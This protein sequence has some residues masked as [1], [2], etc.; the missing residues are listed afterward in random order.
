MTV[1]QPVTVIS[2]HHKGKRI[3]QVHQHPSNA[4][5]RSPMPSI[6][7]HPGVDQAAL[8]SDTAVYPEY[9]PSL[10][11]PILCTSSQHGISYTYLQ[12]ISGQLVPNCREL[13]LRLRFLTRR[14]C[15]SSKLAETFGS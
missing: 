8:M 2:S 4:T 6:S 13:K 10:R 12:K 1:P 14:H 5:P 15:Q 3:L 7:F 9:L 11:L